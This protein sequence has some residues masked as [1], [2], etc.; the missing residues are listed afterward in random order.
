MLD[1][2]HGSRSDEH[3]STAHPHMGA[4]VKSLVERGLHGVGSAPRAF[5][6][7]QLRTLAAKHGIAGA[8]FSERFSRARTLEAGWIFRGAGSMQRAR[9]GL[10]G[11]PG[12]SNS[13]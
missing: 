9:A 12:R 4:T 2:T 6:Y 1:L 3:V 13:V 10:A 5:D 7:W 8:D 11:L